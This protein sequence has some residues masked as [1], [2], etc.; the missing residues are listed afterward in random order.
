MSTE[1]VA[2]EAED[3]PLVPARMLNEFVY[4]PRLAILEW[5]EGEFAPSADTVEGTIRHAAVDKPGYRVRLRRTA[6]ES[7]PDPE[8]PPPEPGRLEQLRSVELSDT[9]LGLIAKIDLVEIEGDR[10]QPVDTKKGKRPHLA[11]GAYDPER[12]QVCAQGLLLRRHGYRCDS[13]FIYYAGSNERVEIDFDEELVA[14]TLAKVSELRATAASGALPPPLVDSPKCV[15]CSLAPICMPDELRFLRDPSS[16]PRQ[17][18]PA[19]EHRFPMYVQHPGATVRKKGDLLQ[20]FDGD[21]KLGEMRTREVSQLVLIGRASATE[22]V[23]R[24]LLGD[25]KPIVHLSSGGWLYGVSDGLPHANVRLRQQQ[26]RTADLPERCLA[27]ARGI[28]VSKL[29]NQRTLL[30]RN[31]G[32]QIP[33]EVLDGIRHAAQSASRATQID[34]LRGHEGMG[35]RH[36]FSGFALMLREDTDRRRFDLEGRNRRPPLDPVNALLSFA[37]AM[38]AREWVTACRSVGFDPYL[39]FYHAP[40]YNRPSLALDLM[41]AFRPI[42]ADSAVVRAINNGE[43]GRDDFV[44]RLGSVNLTDSGR[45]KF[46][47]TFEQRLTQEITHPVFGYRISYRR[48]FEVEARLLARHLLGELPSYEPLTTR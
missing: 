30:R 6:P 4:C 39:G 16:P 5:A 11:K 40:R 7:A 38:L 46:L 13:G 9:E 26:Y 15:R 20:V 8:S 33:S 1:G 32:E 24:E 12:V 34:E 22:P 37:Y 21:E 29:T 25:G 27:I 36:Y 42:C 23:Y 47:R 45:R 35:A 10:V 3:S 41:E 18:L 19:N 31:G 48:V 43:V 44:E 17:L 14:L 28:V 2:I